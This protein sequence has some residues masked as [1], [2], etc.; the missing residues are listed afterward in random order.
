MLRRIP[1]NPAL[2]RLISY[3][4]P[5]KWK[6]AL[7][8]FFMITA[9]AASSLIATLLG[10]LT[11]AGFYNQDAWIILAAPLGLVFIAFLHGGSMFMSNYLLGKVS[12]SV[13]I[14]LRKELFHR[15]LRWPS[16]TYQKNST[17]SVSSKFVFEANVALS[18]AAKSCITLVRDSCQVVALTLVLFWHDWSLAIVSFVIAPCVAYLLRYISEK[19]KRIMASCQESLASILVLVRET[20]R[21]Q[22]EIKLSNA[23][24]FER[25]RFSHV[26][27]V[28]R[29]MMIDMTKT[30]SLGTPLTQLICMTGVAFVLM[31]AMY[32]THIGLLTLGGFVTFLAA[33]LLLMP[34]LRNLASVNAGFVM[35]SVAASSIFTTLDEKEED[36][37]GHE[38]LETCRGNMVFENITLRYPESQHDAVCNFCL[39]VHAG[40]CIA[41]VGHSGSGKSSLVNMIPRFWS[42]TQGRILLD[43][44]DIQTLTLASLR[45]QIAIVSQDV[46]LF[47]D[48]IRKNIAYGV[49]NATDEEIEKA[50]EAAALSEFVQS[51]PNGL[52]TKIGE[53]GNR[54]S[55]GQK[56]R[57]S[58]ARAFL[59]NAPILILDEATSALDNESEAKI[60]KALT[61]LM[62]NRTTFIVAHRLSTIEN[63]TKIIS[64]DAGQV[65]EVGTHEE[66][67]AKDGLYAKLYHLQFFGQQHGNKQV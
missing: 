26:N 32:Q 43:G 10:K 58:I 46:V 63:A 13:L 47:D 18:N 5:Y 31:F 29:K 9:G 37:N 33:L 19:M 65:I 3:L 21:G 6:I 20:H 34:P 39:E 48:T 15:L 51:L 36:D 59:K 30:T 64:M 67:I 2:R 35:M 56:Q 50:I 55:G 23:Y 49:P 52:S 53:A 17:G 28:V 60:K 40:D 38:V 16:Y 24:E 66:L 57:I 41:L 27:E 62:K 54:L 8:V 1:I 11:D 22:R 14:T 7:A 4:P 42:P 12:Q 61:Q 44:K 45:K 25:N